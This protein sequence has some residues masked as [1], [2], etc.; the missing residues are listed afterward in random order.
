MVISL[1]VTVVLGT[2][3]G[4]IA[5]DAVKRADGARSLRSWVAYGAV[6]G[7]LVGGGGPILLTLSYL[8]RHIFAFIMLTGMLPGAVAGG[9][10]GSL[11]SWITT[12]PNKQMQRTRLAQAMEPRR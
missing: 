5:A 4:F 9:L 10:A 12:P 7:A 1:Q 11:C 3:G 8:D 6:R 2:I